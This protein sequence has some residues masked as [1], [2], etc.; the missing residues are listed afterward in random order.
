MS[1]QEDMIF[2]LRGHD[3]AE[4][5]LLPTAPES[6]VLTDG[7][8]V[9]YRCQQALLHHHSDAFGPVCSR[10]ETT[11]KWKEEQ[12]T[13]RGGAVGERGRHLSDS[14]HLAD[15]PQ[16]EQ[17]RLP[18]KITAPQLPQYF[19]PECDDLLIRPRDVGCNVSTVTP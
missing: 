19:V 6:G 10:R 11:R 16:L 14:F 13:K 18:G 12:E 5:T 2:F 15:M 7:L 1:S 8:H 17:K 3:G 9:C 4:Q